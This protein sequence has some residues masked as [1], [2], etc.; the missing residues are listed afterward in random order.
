MGVQ[1]HCRHYY[2][3]IVQKDLLMSL[4]Y[5]CFCF[6]YTNLHAYTCTYTCIYTCVCAMISLNMRLV[7]V[8]VYVHVCVG[9]KLS[10]LLSTCSM[11]Y[12]LKHLVLHGCTLCSKSAVLFKLHIFIEWCNI[13]NLSSALFV[14][15]PGTH[16]YLSDIVHVYMYTHKRMQSHKHVV[17]ACRSDVTNN[18]SNVGTCIYL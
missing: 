15:F 13:V 2:T 17:F 5:F 11:L 10:A 3:Y 7:K 1:F 16:T 9:Q 12:G 4:Q 8:Q 14:S 6:L 18:E